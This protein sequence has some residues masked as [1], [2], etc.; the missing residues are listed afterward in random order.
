MDRQV[1]YDLSEEQVK[2]INILKMLFALFVVY[3]HSGVEDIKLSTS[4]VDVVLPKWFE[5]YSYVLSEVIPRCAVSGFF[6]I[7]SFLLYRKEFT[8]K[9]NIQK[10]LKSLLIP[11]V[12]MNSFWIMAF[13]I[14]QN[15]PQTQVFFANENNMVANFSLFRWLQAYGIGAERPFLYPLWFVRNVFVLNLLA[16][17]I[18]KIIDYAPKVSFVVVSIIFLFI[19]AFPLYNFGYLINPMDLCMW[20][21]GYF[22][23]KYKWN[24]RKIENSKVLVILFIISCVY[25]VATKE[26]NIS[27]VAPYRLCIAISLLFWYA[28]FSKNVNGKIQKWLLRF[29][30]FNFGIY[31][32]HEMNLTFCK[33][34]ITRLFGYSVNVLV[35]EYLFV[36]IVI[37]FFSIV[38]CNILKCIMPKFYS[39]LVGSRV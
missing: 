35:L 31:I 29:S 28:C 4:N 5:Y 21:Y 20:C 14:G 30:N 36:P 33:K 27:W 37:V 17:V 26:L 19:S 39:V 3:I 18:K 32:F 6:F 2:R 24:F 25:R 9:A 12:L 13:Y 10:R 11:Y 8:W 23:V 34:L 7:S 15:I 16:V 22:F 1:I 38:L